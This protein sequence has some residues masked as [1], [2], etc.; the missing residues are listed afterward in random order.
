[1]LRDLPLFRAAATEAGFSANLSVGFL[2]RDLWRTVESGTPSPQARLRV[3]S[4][5]TDAGIR[6]GVLMAPVLPYLTDS[7][8]S[9]DATVAAIAAAGATHVTGIALHLRPGAK[10]WFLGWL[11]REHPALVG[12]Y[13]RLYGRGSYAPEGYRR[14]LSARITAAARRHGLDRRDAASGRWLEAATLPRDL[15]AEPPA[16]LTLL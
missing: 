3:C 16:Q 11:A 7:E 15:A 12:P 9:I 1:V 6:C 2:D 5:F 10:E 8:D 13:R 14:E 4:T